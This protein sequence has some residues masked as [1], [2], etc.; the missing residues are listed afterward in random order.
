MSE[1]PAVRHRRVRESL[2]EAAG[3][4]ADLVQRADHNGRIRSPAPPPEEE[5][6]PPPTVGTPGA[7]V[8]TG[9]HGEPRPRSLNDQISEATRAGDVS[10]A[11]ALNSEKLAAAVSAQ[12][13]KEI[14]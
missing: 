1:D 14:Q 13:A 6:P 12:R 8:G 7:K 10:R 3:Q 4:L 2:R 11:I 9:Q 5:E